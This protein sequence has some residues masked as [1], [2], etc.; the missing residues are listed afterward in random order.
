MD[1]PAK[2]ARIA[3]KT[4]FRL[5]DADAQAFLG[6]MAK[7]YRFTLQELQLVSDMALDRLRWKEASL[8]ADWPPGPAT[9]VRS[10]GPCIGATDRFATARR[11]MRRS[12]LP[13]GRRP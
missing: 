9:R 10:S 3:E 8:Q 2:F 4:S 5:L 11:A 7:R 12:P 1:Y 6:D 13:T